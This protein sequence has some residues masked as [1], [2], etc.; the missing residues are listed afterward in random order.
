[1]KNLLNFRRSSLIIFFIISLC[2]ILIRCID[3]GN[4]KNEQQV[5]ENTSFSQFVGSA[6]CAKCH[7]QIYDSFELTSHALTSQI[8]NEKNIKGPF[9]KGSNIFHYN[10]DIF[11]S[12]EKTDSGFYE[13]EHNNGKETVLGRMDISIGSGN[14]GKTYL[15][16]KN[17]YLYQL[18]VSYL[19]SIHGWV[20]SPGANTEFLVNRIVMPRC[21]ECHSTYAGDITLGFSGK[22][23][24]PTQIIYGVGC[25]K[26]HGAGAQHVEY[27][28]E[29]PNATTAKYIINPGTFSRQLSLD[30]CRSCHGG[31]I[32]SIK[33]AFTFKPGD[34]LKD[35]FRID[36]TGKNAGIDVHGDQYDLLAKSKCF[37]TST[38]L[39]CLSC[40]NTHDNERGNITLFSQRCMTC[41][42][43]EHG[44]FCTIKS[45]SVAT[46][47]SNCIDCHMPEQKSKLIEMKIS[48]S[49]KMDEATLRTHYITI[50]PDATKKYLAKIS[51][52]TS[53]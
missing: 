16:W 33:P 19:T 9:E 18:Q 42:N 43:Q 12:M 44:T 23:F 7:K 47:S 53:K 13:V 39:T 22:K 14:K 25:E 34:K 31:G 27:Q 11:V 10:H 20:N 35:Y 28:T 50:Y 3:S 24:D 2:F 1:M 30:F 15:T 40:H 52:I 32:K 49:N 8:V 41:H 4:K 37:I 21:L 26:C 48:N 6:T 51:A 5:S 17:D 45:E 38:T 36:T 29:H 46:I